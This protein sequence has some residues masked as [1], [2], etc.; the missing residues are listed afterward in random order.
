MSGAGMRLKRLLDLHGDSYANAQEK[1]KVSRETIRRMVNGEEPPKMALYLRQIALAYGIDEFAL[2]EG[3]TPKGEFE[4][5]VHHASP[6]QR[7]EWLM[8]SRAE[9]VK[10][11]L[12][13]LRL[14]YPQYVAPKMLAA[15]TG[16]PEAEL[17]SLLERWEISPPD[18]KVAGDL[19]DALHGLTG[20][21]LSWFHWGG[22]AGNW[23]EGT[24][25]LVRVAR[26]SRTP[27]NAKS[28]IDV[29]APS[30]S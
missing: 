30:W 19:V 29:V 11:V 22:L 28:L 6:A 21:S 1:S 18:R 24:E 10:L 13:F 4:W 9:R 5:N 3:A 26:W 23:Q 15:A 27:G 16:L 7:L 20:I 2:L 12:D 17:R 25:G 8:L 14:R